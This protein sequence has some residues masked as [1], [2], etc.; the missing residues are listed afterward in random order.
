MNRAIARTLS[1]TCIA[2]LAA[3]DGRP[4]EAE[5]LSRWPGGIVFT[6]LESAPPARGRDLPEVLRAPAAVIGRGVSVPVGP[7]RSDGSRLVHRVGE[8]I[9]EYVRVTETIAPDGSKRTLFEDLETTSL[10]IEARGE[11]R[12]NKLEGVWTY[13][14]PN[15][16]KRAMGSF[17]HDV[18]SG[19]WEFWLENGAPDTA[20]SGVYE[21]NA[22]VT[23]AP[24]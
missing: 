17:V 18:M 16:Q 14:H 12:D 1:V 20:H 9:Y 7:P 19:P 13:W 2:W 3:C 11:Y 4:T 15:G 6:N 21:N 5:L 8:W 22:L 23:A 10:G 24:R